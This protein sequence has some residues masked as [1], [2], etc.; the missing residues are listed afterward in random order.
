M[1]TE[2]HY[3]A[4]EWYKIWNEIAPDWRQ[5]DREL[6]IT[7]Y[8]KKLKTT[9]TN[10]STKLD[11]GDLQ[12]G[13]DGVLQL[14]DRVSKQEVKDIQAY[15]REMLQHIKTYEAAFTSKK[16][17][18]DLAKLER[19]LKAKQEDSQL[20]AEKDKKDVESGAITDKDIKRTRQEFNKKRLEFSAYTGEIT[21]KKVK[22][23]EALLELPKLISELKIKADNYNR[24]VKKRED[25]IV[26]ELDECKEWL[27]MYKANEGALTPLAMPKPKEGAATP[28]PSITDALKSPRASESASRNASLR[29]VT[30]EEPP[31]LLGGDNAKP[32]TKVNPADALL[33]RARGVHGKA[34]RLI[35]EHVHVNV[36]LGAEIVPPDIAKKNLQTSTVE[37]LDTEKK[38]T[39]L[40]IARYDAELNDTGKAEVYQ[41]TITEL[42]EIILELNNYVT[43]EGPKIT[44]LRNA[45]NETMAA[46]RANPITAIKLQESLNAEIKKTSDTIDEYEK[47]LTQVKSFIIS[48]SEQIPHLEAKIASLT[49]Q[50]E[51]T[52]RA[53]EE[54]RSYINQI[55]EQRRV[56][57]EH[58]DSEH[59]KMKEEGMK[60]FE[61]DVER[62]Q[63]DIASEG[64]NVLQSLSDIY[65]KVN[66]HITD[67]DK[68]TKETEI[69]LAPNA[70]GTEDLEAQMVSN[71]KYSRIFQELS[72]WRDTTEGLSAEFDALLL[73]KN[74]DVKTAKDEAIN[75]GYID[76]AA[77]ATPLH[78]KDGI[79]KMVDSL[80]IL[81]DKIRDSIDPQLK[82][83][84]T[85]LTE[86]Y[87]NR[88]SYEALLNKLK[89]TEE[90]AL[91]GIKKGDELLKSAREVEVESST[92]SPRREPPRSG[93]LPPI[94]SNSAP[95]SIFNRTTTA[96][97]LPAVDVCQ[98]CNLPMQPPTVETDAWNASFSSIKNTIEGAIAPQNVLLRKQKLIKTY[99]LPLLIA[100]DEVLQI[101]ENTDFKTRIAKT[102]NYRNDANV[103]EFLDYP[104]AL[105]V[106]ISDITYF[107]ANIDTLQE[108]MAKEEAKKKEKE[109]RKKQSDE[110]VKK[111]EATR[112]KDKEANKLKRDTDA[113]AVEHA[114]AEK[115]RKELAAAAAAATKP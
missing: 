71:K 81:F 75:N 35:D 55:D 27:V 91:A 95:D 36:S 51:V 40:K 37:E 44:S 85:Q 29:D 87:K 101:L 33:D 64:E 102:N 88:K 48:M 38:Y 60:K 59:K 79:D 24:Y 104:R 112:I 2:A 109:E 111:L 76:T 82:S 47:K 45:C 28:R 77:Y 62:M 49:Q 14:R 13:L 41:A 107:K 1:Q 92:D 42:R 9:I 115:L 52:A 83:Q 114:A 69:M 89:V 21:T 54:A 12:A 103:D 32:E 105:K 56:T 18:V 100:A 3:L 34:Q 78:G 110:A 17:D 31:S 23:D 30:V 53:L 22:K 46:S 68:H 86:E 106:F 57:Q 113:A 43:D 19:K 10:L 5:E 108:R 67:C 72:E 96:Q 50:R 84:Y 97:A 99:L 65:S 98:R 63:S 26:E 70:S 74:K 8:M 80:T 73:R 90:S 15:T 20:Q 16:L 94:N 66:D 7:V 4:E 61:D 58:E 93:G 39:E 25:H 11:Q 6:I